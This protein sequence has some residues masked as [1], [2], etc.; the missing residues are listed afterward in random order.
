MNKRLLVKL[1]NIPLR[2]TEIQYLVLNNGQIIKCIDKKM[3]E[4]DW[5]NIKDIPQPVIT[6]HI[7]WGNKYG[8]I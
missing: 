7:K 6:S 4:P 1:I 2:L 8:N 5:D 3:V